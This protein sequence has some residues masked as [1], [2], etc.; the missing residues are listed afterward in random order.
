MKGFLSKGGR[1][2]PGGG[3]GAAG[4]D[5]PATVEQKIPEINFTP[6]HCGRKNKVTGAAIS[7]AYLR[8][9]QTVD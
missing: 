7:H 2:R 3:N 6:T 9:K 8:G 4:I 1:R 5:G